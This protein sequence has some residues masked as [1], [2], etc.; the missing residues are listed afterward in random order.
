MHAMTGIKIIPTSDD[1]LLIFIEHS[2]KRRWLLEKAVARPPNSNESGEVICFDRP[3]QTRI[4]LRD[5][6]LVGIRFFVI[7]GPA[8]T[9]IANEIRSLVP[10][11]SH[12]ALLGWWDRAVESNDIDDKVDAVLFLGT[13]APPDAQPDVRDRLLAALADPDADVRNAAIV[14]AGYTE[15]ASSFR[16]ALERI[17]SSDAN[18]VARE[19]ATVVLEQWNRPDR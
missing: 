12:A 3:T 10:S 7:A 15:W 19:R 16:G 5:D 13:G 1:P 11:Y 14:A 2:R 17:E 9:D 18:E 6:A 4:T 8:A